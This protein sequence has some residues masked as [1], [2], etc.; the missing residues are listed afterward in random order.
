MSNRIFIVGIIVITLWV[1]YI[2]GFGIWDT[3]YA[4]SAEIEK[5]D[6][7]N[8]IWIHLR[9]ISKNNSIYLYYGDNGTMYRVELVQ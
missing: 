5:V 1:I 9:N 6:K 4:P 7:D 3:F 8:T 2:I